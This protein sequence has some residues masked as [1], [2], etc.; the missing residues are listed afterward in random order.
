MFRK[1]LVAY[2]GSDPAKAALTEAL[3]LVRGQPS[4]LEVVHVLFDLPLNVAF[5]NAAL[6]ESSIQAQH[7]AAQRLLDE[8]IAQARAADVV[9]STAILDDPGRRVAEVI[10]SHAVKVHAGLVVVGS[11]GRRGMS[12]ALLGS[13]AELVARLA[14]MPVLIVKAPPTT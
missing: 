14:P 11:H 7:D 2:D 6:V 12:R 5:S 13:D 9:P 10:V 8:A 1:V 3:R 4:E